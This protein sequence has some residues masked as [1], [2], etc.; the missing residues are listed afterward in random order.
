MESHERREVFL[1]VDPELDID[2]NLCG[3]ETCCYG[4][5]S[6]PIVRDY[7]TLHFITGGL[8]TLTLLG[9]K[10]IFRKGDV[11][12]MLP[13]TH[14][15][16]NEQIS[17]ESLQFCW[18]GF[19]GK[20]SE[21]YMKRFSLSA[22]N[23]VMRIRMIDEISQEI[24]LLTDN[25]YEN[26]SISK[27]SVLSSIYKLF[28]LLESSII[29]EVSIIHSDERNKLSWQIINYITHN[30]QERLD[31]SFLC[32]HFNI[33][34]SYLWKIITQTTG[35]SPQDFIRISRIC[36]ARIL[37]EKTQLSIG[38][39]ASTVGI[40]DAAYFHHVFK[41][42]ENMTPNEYRKWRSIRKSNSQ[43]MLLSTVKE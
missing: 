15:Q 22:E 4:F 37:L 34:R 33:S 30:L 32:N 7:Y 9:K 13:Y 1:N 21:N 2:M 17:N 35:H 19:T 11:F 42:I 38:M 18:F 24:I 3:Y 12:S 29:D 14:A 28:Y 5:K 36:Q 41:S 27:F 43:T 8:G 25:I 20:L 10:F 31:V 26:P 39:I 16:Y 40:H 23:P 6:L